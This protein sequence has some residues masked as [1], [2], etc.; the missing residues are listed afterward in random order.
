MRVYILT[1]F[2]EIFSSVLS[3]GV[4]GRSKTR[5]EVINIRDFA[6]DKH[7]TVD[8]APYGGFGGMVMLP[9]VV[10][11]AFDSLPDEAKAKVIIPTPRGR[12]FRQEDAIALSKEKVITFICPHYK[13]IDERVFELT[14][15]VRYSVGDY[16]L[17]GGE[18]PAL[19]MIDAIVRLLPDVLGNFQSAELDSF[20]GKRY[21]GA[22]VYTRPRLFRG[23]EVP[24]ILVSGDHKRVL[25]WKMMTGLADT[26]KY[27][28]E[29]VEEK[30]L[31][32]EEKKLLQMIKGKK[33]E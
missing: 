4:I 30:K 14:G 3:C 27:R 33:G 6:T 32:E 24:D 29:L 5:F 28:P 19:V 18:L 20:Y 7:Q 23:L 26:L 13:G 11:Q 17:T 15:A 10:M 22:P 25:R 21:L 9:E 16:V 31:T 2:P 1:I 12:L 8:D